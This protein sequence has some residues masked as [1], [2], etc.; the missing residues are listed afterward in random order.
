MLYAAEQDR[1]QVKIR[2][3][4]YALLVTF[5]IPITVATL[6]FIYRKDDNERELILSTTW[7]N[8]M[9]KSGCKPTDLDPVIILHN[10]HFE[11]S[12]I[13]VLATGA[14]FGQLFESQVMVNTG[15]LNASQWLWYKTSTSMIAARSLLTL[16]ITAPFMA[17]R[18]FFAN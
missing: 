9:D 13:I 12:G 10:R 7:K 16:V 17:L 5:V 1:Y 3:L 6:M 2:H 14:L 8:R 11:H 18:Y 15:R 4:L